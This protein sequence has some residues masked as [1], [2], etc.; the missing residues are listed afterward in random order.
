MH[1]IPEVFYLF[2]CISICLCAVFYLSMCLFESK[3]RNITGVAG[4]SA[5]GDVPGKV[6]CL[7]CVPNIG[8]GT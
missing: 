5:S 3:A 1:W 6:L 4:T 2:M 7:S 8:T